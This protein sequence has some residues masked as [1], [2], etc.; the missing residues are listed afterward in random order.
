MKIAA[1]LLTVTCA[2]VLALD[3]WS[4]H[5][6]DRVLRQDSPRPLLEPIIHAAR[7]EWEPLQVVATGLDSEMTGLQVQATPL[8][9]STGDII[10]PP[11]VLREHYVAVTQPSELSPGIANHYPDAL[12]P[13]SFPQQPGPSTGMSNQPFWLD[14][15]VPP[16][17]VPGNYTG[18]VTLTT[19]SGQQ[20]QINYMLHVWDFTLP[21]RPALKSS[22]FIVWR[23]IAE[24]HGFSHES[25]EA[26]PKLQ[27]VLDAYY[28]MLA[29]HRLCPHEVWATYPDAAEPTSEMSFQAM[30]SGLKKHLLQRG[31][32]TIGLPL[33]EAWPFNDPLG[34]DRAD[35]KAYVARYHGMCAELGCAERLYKIFGELDEPHDARAYARVRQWKKFFDE[36]YQ[37]KQVRVP[38][39]VTVQPM[40][41]NQALQ[42]VAGHADILTPHVSALWE[43]MHGKGAQQLTR[44][45]LQA[46][47]KL[48]TYTALVQAPDEW[49]LAQG[50]PTRLTHGHPPV[51]LLDYPAINH[52]LLAWLAPKYDITG[53][54][55]WD[56]SHFPA[57]NFDPWQN[58]GTYPHDNG[59]VY[60][61]D[62]FFIYPARQATHGYEGPVA[63]IR[64]KW[65]RECMDDYDY[66]ALLMSSE[67]KKVAIQRASSFARSLTD[68]DAS[69]E[70]LYAARL[71]I[72]RRLARNSLRQRG[73]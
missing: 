53:F 60:N 67:G 1:I 46:G 34:K 52:R 47:G 62:G 56:T 43:D 58:A 24:V 12:V 66:L 35:A 33:W 54:T 9:N 39:L 61:G 17:A 2:P 19:E 71:D 26:E 6:M 32:S 11:V 22:M 30:A 4:T 55:Y 3:F 68:W 7:G 28:D 57:G 38:L 15:Y 5:G 59:E 36:V 65:L 63:S 73:S 69:V 27:Q 44:K 70:A 18:T 16:S 25:G 49:K 37:E 41:E 13:Q 51:W 21:E 20:R 42:A 72:A 40:L 45:H 10:P 14:V 31:A 23:R 64:L 48:W 50:R 29:A 8:A